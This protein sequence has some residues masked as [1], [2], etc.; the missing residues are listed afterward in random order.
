M[1]I[2]DNYNLLFSQQVNLLRT[3]GKD[4]FP[5]G[6]Y[7]SLDDILTSLKVDVIIEP[8]ILIRAIPSAL[9]DAVNSWR[10]EAN[11]L[12]SLI[13]EAEDKDAASENY[14][15]AR[16]KMEDICNE[17]E[18]WAT[19][20]LR[21]LYDP[22][23]NV[24]KLYPEEMA[25]EYG[26]TCMDELLVSTLAHETMHAYFNRPRHKSFPYVIHVEEPLAEFGMLL[27]LYEK[28]SG[29]YSWAYQDVSNKKTCYRYGA[30]LMSQHLS[31]GPNSSVR[32]Y[33]E[34]YKIKLNNYPMPTVNPVGGTIAL[35]MKG[36]PVNSSV[37]VGSNRITPHWQDV[38]KCPPRYFYDKATNTLGLDGDWSVGPKQNGS[39][40]VDIRIM[41]EHHN[42][43]TQIYLGDNFTKDH[44]HS[45]LDLLSKYDV[46]VSSANKQFYAN[47][48]VPFC[49]KDNK[50]FL[51][52]CG[53]GLYEICRNGKWGV[54]DDQ[55]NPVVPCKYDCVW[56]FD[57][58]DLIMVR[59]NHQYGLVNKQ[60]Q[61]QVPV[62]YEDITE[63]KDG[64]YT[65]KQ[66]GNKFKID[67]NGNRL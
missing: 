50:P 16:K 20:P 32:Q 17:I 3:R 12:E 55:L 35:P 21:G 65:V 14:L 63:D 37:Q 53:D 61:E 5:I 28:V 41:I 25:Q 9:N 38:F 18:R 52:D 60:G 40:L 11:R 13:A 66:N 44:Y 42:T 2:I 15:E 43:I 7:Q 39:I 57:R 30:Q 45:S 33:L 22:V 6:K 47:N 59:I 62:I 54:I 64:A 58:N 4:L 27:Y 56:S 34:A 46:I 36:N 48:G 23:K 31:Q 1:N 51:S 49:K 8:G 19:M 26:G 67:K 24:I 29:Y 10:E